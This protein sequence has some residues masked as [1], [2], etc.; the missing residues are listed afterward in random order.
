M[1][2]R[3][4]VSII[5]VLAAMNF[6]LKSKN[7]FKQTILYSCLDVDRFAMVSSKIF[8]PLL[9]SIHEY[10]K[11]D[12]TCINITHSIS[13]FP[14]RKIL[15]GQISLN[16]YFIKIKLFG[17]FISIFTRN[18][19][20]NFFELKQK[21]KLYECII[22]INNVKYIF[23]IQPPHEL[24]LAAHNLSIKVIEPIHG[25]NL[26]V[27]DNV[28][29][30]T[31]H[32]IPDN[33]LPD[34]YLTFDKQTLN[35]LSFFLKGRAAKPFYM[36]HPWHVECYKNTSTLVNN[37]FKSDRSFDSYDK[38]ILL[39]LQWGYDGEREIFNGLI[40]NGVIHEAILEVIQKYSNFYWLI[41]LHPVQMKG[42][43]YLKHRT[44]VYELAKKFE[45]I[46]YELA[47]STPL[48][49]LLSKVDGHIT[50]SS[51]S[52]GEAAQLRVPSLMLCPTLREGGALY[53]SFTIT[54][55][56]EIISFQEATT[57]NVYNWINQ[58]RKKD[59]QLR[60]ENNAKDV[61]SVLKKVMEFTST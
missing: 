6:S 47:T 54:D 25:M 5:K 21:V 52:A 38:I 20:L 57:E 14:S 40:S 45:N 41:R 33:Q 44:L 35:S 30:N 37:N 9:S 50:M 24:C 22:R 58:I 43:R 34:F 19:N 28:F 10:L 11:T 17:K 48:P 39:S 51:G 27:N 36:P 1:L 4:I 15:G 3:K 23:A 55:C 61:Q 12:F 18:N 13:F 31:I 46:E 60:Y 16:F 8:S 49:I 26:S 2:L 56:Q 42:N 29:M 53:G 32:S 59:E 7:T